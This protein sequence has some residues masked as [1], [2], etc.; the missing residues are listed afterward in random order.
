MTSLDELVE[1]LEESAA[2]S[3]DLTEP[4]W[5]RVDEADDGVSLGLKREPSGLLGWTAPFGCIAVGAIAGG[6]AHP[7]N[8]AKGQSPVVRCDAPKGVRIVCLMDR[9]G[10]VCA[11]ATLAD[12]E[13]IDEAPSS[14]RMIDNFRRCFR[15]PTDPPDT[16]PQEF[17]SLLWLGEV[18]A[19]GQ[20]EHRALSWQQ[21]AH[22]HPAARVLTHLGEPVPLDH[23]A[24]VLRAAGSAWTWS[25][26]RE[27]AQGEGWLADQL[28][29]GLA[30]WMDDGMFSRWLLDGH[31]S[32]DELLVSI[33]SV[34]SPSAARRV[35]Q[36]L[37]AAGVCA[38]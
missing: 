4:I 34:L 13:V 12:G 38:A 27:H 19:V 28:P 31:R 25:R 9:E 8:P 35:R 18:L 22:L 33:R 21:A 7:L 20:Q 17:L 10:R 11:K 15:L 26:L 32:L 3:P 30:A 14:G 37:D 5:V 29:P 36:A 23:F 1:I 2:D 6:R 16:T 24:A